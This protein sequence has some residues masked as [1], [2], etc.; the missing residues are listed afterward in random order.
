MTKRLISLV[1]IAMVM[2]VCLPVVSGAQAEYTRWVYTEN[3]RSL[4]VRSQPSTGNNEIG[5]LKYGDRVNVINTLSNGWTTIS[6]VHADNYVAYVQTRFLV[7]YQPAPWKPA[8]SKAS[9]STGTTSSSSSVSYEKIVSEMNA[10]FASAKKVNVPYAVTSRP[11]RATGWVN[12]RWAPTTQAER[13]TTCPQGKT[14]TVLAEL[15]N[16]Y[17]VE[18]PATGMIGFISR[19]YVSR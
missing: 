2:A 8:S 6:W 19:Q 1:L 4:N 15:R 16:W 9:T 5:S 13:I 3:G 18:D 14:L 17:Q 7:D 11:S 12:L 10:E